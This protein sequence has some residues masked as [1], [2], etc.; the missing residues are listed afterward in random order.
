MN[1]IKTIHL[2]KN[3]PTRTWQLG[4]IAL[5]V[6]IGITLYFYSLGLTMSSIMIA[7]FSFSLAIILLLQYFGVITETHPIIFAAVCI[8][9]IVSGFV[10]GA[11]TGQYFYFFPLVVVIPIVVKNK[12]SS[13]LEFILTYAAIMISFVTCFY[14]GHAVRPIE[15]ISNSVANKIIYSNAGSAM[16][17][18]VSFSIANIFYENKFLSALR[19]IAQIQSHEMRKPVAS[20]IGLMDVWKEEKYVYDEEI[21]T[22]IEKATVELDEKIH[23]IIKHT[24][25]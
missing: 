23:L 7:C 15:Q 4:M 14:V 12:N 10:E 17:I 25:L 24:T 2:L 18:T 9:L 20:I 22:M 16:F 13:N 19:A 3:I 11:T 8:L 6:S 5:I 1:D 21:V